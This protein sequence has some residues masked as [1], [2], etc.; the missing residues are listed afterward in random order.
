MKNYHP[1]N[2][3]EF[4]INEKSIPEKHTR[5]Y[6]QWEKRFLPYYQKNLKTVKYKNFIELFRQIGILWYK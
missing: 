3:Q 5:F 6:Q 1:N 4:Q 2:F